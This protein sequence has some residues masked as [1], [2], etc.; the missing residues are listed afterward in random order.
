VF[1]QQF[2]DADPQG[3]RQ[4]FEKLRFENLQRA[5]A[6]TGSRHSDIAL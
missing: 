1:Q 4:S 3:M 5:G 6:S 2:E